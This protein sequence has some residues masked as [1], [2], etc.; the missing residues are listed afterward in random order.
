MVVRY[1]HDVKRFYSQRFCDSSATTTVFLASFHPTHVFL[2][3]K[4]LPSTLQPKI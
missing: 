4:N 3:I 1:S 2:P